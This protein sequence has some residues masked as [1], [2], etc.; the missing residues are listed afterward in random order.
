MDNYT[1]ASGASSASTKTDSLQVRQAIAK[2]LKQ[3]RAKPRRE[4]PGEI[5]NGRDG[6]L[7]VIRDCQ[8]EA[9]QAA[10][11]R[12]LEAEAAENAHFAVQLEE[13]MDRKE[14]GELLPHHAEWLC[15]CYSSRYDDPKGCPIEPFH[16]AFQPRPIV[17]KGLL[18]IANQVASGKLDRER[19][20]QIVLATWPEEKAEIN[21][22]FNRA[23]SRVC[24]EARS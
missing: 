17:W 22:I 2:Q 1:V 4:F 10:N 7:I 5:Y 11:K 13:W 19:A 18:R 8:C 24:A 9:C 12:Q 6:R 23:L 20:R 15:A 3:L 14:R 21:G 16:P